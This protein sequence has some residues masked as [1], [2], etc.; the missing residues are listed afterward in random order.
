MKGGTSSS[1]GCLGAQLLAAARTDRQTDGWKEVRGASQKEL[2]VGIQRKSFPQPQLKVAPREGSSLQKCGAWGLPW[3]VSE[4]LGFH[5]ARRRGT[6]QHQH[7]HQALPGNLLQKR[8]CG[9][10]T[11]R[12][13]VHREGAVL[14][15]PRPNAREGS[16]T[17]GYLNPRC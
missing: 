3:A 5:P 16:C 14:L 8:G 10:T 9:D 6:C 1:G 15:V 13:L 12:E 17:E 11:C 2:G 4:C 7:Q